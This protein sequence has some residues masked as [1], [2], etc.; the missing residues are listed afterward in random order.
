MRKL[1]CLAA[2]AILCPV[3]FSASGSLPAQG[4]SI[5]EAGVKQHDSGKRAQA[6]SVLGLLAGDRKAVRMA[7]AALGDSAREVAEAAVEALGEMNARRSIPKIKALIPNGD[8]KT[9]VVVAAV[10][11]KFNDPEAYSIYY[12]ILTG[13]R[14]AGGSIFDG[15]R[16]RKNLEKIG[17]E[18]AIGLIPYSGIATGAYNYF[19]QNGALNL[20]VEAT[21]AEALAFDPDPKSEKALIDACFGRKE[22]I[23]V[24]ALRALA[25]RGDPK[26]LAQIAP[27]M[28][29]SKALVSYT[30]AAAVVHL[31]SLK[32]RSKL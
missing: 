18:E 16:D 27:T 11:R 6:V 3:C 19:A 30:A 2:A 7:E 9:I 26:V 23:E 8:A 21:A 17:I 28:Y 31:T 1:F 25:K 29:D 10:L 24:A 13:T 22:A 12:Q 20:T 5:I 4:W 15:I 32:N 14:K